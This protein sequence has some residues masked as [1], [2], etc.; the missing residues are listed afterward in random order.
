MRETE[1]SPNRRFKFA[2]R[3]QLFIGAHNETLPV[4]AMGFPLMC[5]RCLIL[6]A[7]GLSF[8]VSHG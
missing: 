4:G 7:N 8:M 6:A 1:R 2:K 3:R 5:C